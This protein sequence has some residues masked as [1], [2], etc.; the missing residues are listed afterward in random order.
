MGTGWDELHRTGPHQPVVVDANLERGRSAVQLHAQRG[1][2]LIHGADPE[3]AQ[4]RDRPERRTRSS[5]RGRCPP[6]R[7]QVQKTSRI[8]RSRNRYERHAYHQ[9]NRQAGDEH[10]PLANPPLRCCRRVLHHEHPSSG[11]QLA[12]RSHR[13]DYRRRMPGAQAADGPP[14]YET[15]TGVGDATAN[16]ASPGGPR[17]DAS[18]LAYNGEIL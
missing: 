2:H 17:R 11:F 4:L 18:Q 8:P 16:S 6:R 1:G 10:L 15:S 13:H 3:L 7:L 5:R 14:S 12:R 9:R